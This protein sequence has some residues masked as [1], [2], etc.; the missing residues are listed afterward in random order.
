MLGCERRK[1]NEGCGVRVEPKV[2]TYPRNVVAGG[3]ARIC[4]SIRASA[5]ITVSLIWV[6]RKSGLS[7]DRRRGRRS[8]V[9]EKPSYS[10]L[11]RWHVCCEAFSKVSDKC[12][13]APEVSM[14]RLLASAISP[15]ET[16]PR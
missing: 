7:D 8:V 15:A 12:Q 9:S 4:A 14:I 1:P 3:V 2:L 13:V 6:S 10:N 11:P 16:I 5:D